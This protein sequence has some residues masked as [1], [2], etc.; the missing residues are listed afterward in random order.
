MRPARIAI[1]IVVALLGLVW[2]GQGIGLLP[3]EAMRGQALWAIVGLAL[4][5]AGVGLGIVEWRRA[6]ARSG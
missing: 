6:N 2:F 3:G 5:V 1:A 4:V